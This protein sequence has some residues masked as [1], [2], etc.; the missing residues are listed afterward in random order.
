C[1]QALGFPWTF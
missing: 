1:M